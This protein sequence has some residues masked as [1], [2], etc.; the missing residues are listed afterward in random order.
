MDGARWKNSEKRIIEI[1]G[2]MNG[3]GF[4]WDREPQWK[5]ERMNSL[6]KFILKPQYSYISLCFRIWIEEGC[7]NPLWQMD[8]RIGL[9]YILTCLLYANCLQTLMANSS[10]FVYASFFCNAKN[11]LAFCKIFSRNSNPQQLYWEG[12]LSFNDNKTD[13]SNKTERCWLIDKNCFSVK[14]KVEWIHNF[15]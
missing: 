15:Y 3:L 14:R 9:S 2:L 1:P 12:C 6:P 13:C 8:A 11:G 10:S 7:G 4:C 5:L